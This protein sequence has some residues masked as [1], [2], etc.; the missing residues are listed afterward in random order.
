MKKLFLMRGA[1]AVGKS[2]FLEAYPH[3]T[4]GYDQART[5]MS[6]QYP[7]LD[8]G[9]SRAV[10]QDADKTVVEFV[11]N[12]AKI[13]M[14]RGETLF[15]DNTFSRVS[16]VSEWSKLAAPYLYE[17]IVVD[18]QNG[19]TVDEALRRNASRE[20]FKFVNEEVVIKMFDKIAST[21]VDPSL[22]RTITPAQ[23]EAELQT[24]V[25]DFTDRERV[26]VIGDVQG[27]DTALKSLLAEVAPTDRDHVVFAGDLFDRGLE[28]P[29][30]YRTVTDLRKTVPTTFVM[31]NHDHHVIECVNQTALGRYRDTRESL[32]QM[33]DEGIMSGDVRN[34]CAEFVPFVYAAFGPDN[35]YGSR[36]LVTHGGIDIDLSEFEKDGALNVAT[37]PDR[38]FEMGSG[39]RDKTYRAVGDYS[40]DIDAVFAD[41]SPSG[42]VLSFHGHRFT[43]ETSGV[44]E[45]GVAV[46]F[47]LETKVEFD[48]GRLTAAV[49]TRGADGS[50]SV[51]RVSVANT[52]TCGPERTE[53]DRNAAAKKARKDGGRSL[54]SEL[55]ASE[56]VNEKVIEGT[57]LSAFNFTRDAFFNAQWNELTTTARGLFL[58]SETGQVAGRGYS[59]FFNVGER[60]ET[61]EDSVIELFG[62]GGT[63]RVEH[64]LNGFLGIAFAHN[65]EL[66]CWSKSG[67]SKFADAFR[68][69]L[70]S[71]LESSDKTVDEFTNALSKSN[72]SLTF[73]VLDPSDPHIV[74]DGVG[75]TLLH[76]V[77]NTTNSLILLDDVADRFGTEFGFSRPTVA[78]G[79]G[80]AFVQAILNDAASS[81]TEGVVLRHL[82]T[83]SMVKVKSNSYLAWKSLRTLFGKLVKLSAVEYRDAMDRLRSS[84]ALKDQAVVAVIR[85]LVEVTNVSRPLDDFTV[86]QLG[87]VAGARRVVDIPAVREVVGDDVLTDYTAEVALLVSQRGA[88]DIDEDG[89]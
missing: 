10:G 6:G 45:D 39:S 59:K 14:S 19:V 16:E 62:D 12:A 58:D 17:V 74:S 47:G 68:T 78:T 36:L 70:V 8:G 44:S 5:M 80:V 82:P 24:P 42:R 25:V 53:A 7:T 30:V 75:V 27:C 32:R 21:S 18:C 57:G 60:P 88:S 11:K 15:I 40:V 55:R 84:T 69:L 81:V 50:V 26:I 28:N 66:F 61:T 4:L 65:G 79:S 43:P 9:V 22:A 34:L 2:T 72:V 51:E 56:F 1:P 33:V 77:A 13:R 49:V 63:V 73:E 87:G 83:G 71:S 41:K 86:S 54:L 38:F 64:K 46:S 29:G 52:V 67:P 3:N 31:G 23:I 89:F 76:A 85:K 48:G 37:L 20:P 35:S